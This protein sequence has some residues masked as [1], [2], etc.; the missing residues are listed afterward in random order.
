MCTG[1]LLA[2]WVSWSRSVVVRCLGLSEVTPSGR[3][4]FS[5]AADRD[6]STKYHVLIEVFYIQS[7]NI[8]KHFH[9]LRF[10][11]QGCKGVMTRP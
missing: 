9:S 7:L 6:K 3:N 4:T 10:K 5:S 11:V 2:V 1:Q 8:Q